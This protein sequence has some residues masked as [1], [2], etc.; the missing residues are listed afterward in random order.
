MTST[1]GKEPAAMPWPTSVDLHIVTPRKNLSQPTFPQPQT[2]VG[3]SQTSNTLPLAEA[4]TRVDNHSCNT[5]TSSSENPDLSPDED[6][7]DDRERFTIAYN[8]LAQRHGIRILVPGDFPS[9]T[10]HAD[11]SLGS[12]RGSWISKVLRQPSEQSRKAAA[13]SDKPTLRHHRSHSFIHNLQNNKRDGLK[14]LDLRALVRLCGRS[15][16][17]LPPEYAPFSLTLP[18]CFRALAQA[19]VQHADTRGIF[20]VSGSARA[21]DALYDYYC[22]NN[23]T[24]MENVS[25][26]T[27]CP[28]LPTHIKCNTHDVAGTFKRLLAGLPG[29]ILGSLSLFDAL[30]TIHSQLQGDPESYRTKE[31]RLRARLIAL[32]IGTVKSQYQRELICAVF[33][34]LCLVG[35]IAENAPRE[36]EN[37]HPLPTTDLMGYHALGI[38]FGPLLVGDLIDSYI[39]EVANPSAGLVLLP[40][41]A[42]RSKKEGHHQKHRHSYE[43]YHEHSHEHS[44][45]HEHKHE[46]KHRYEHQ[47]HERKHE[48]KHQHVHQH[49]HK[50][51]LDGPSTKMPFSVNKINVANSITEMLIVH[52]REVVRQIRDTGSVKTRRHGPNMP[53][54]HPESVPIELSLSASI[55]SFSLKE[56]VYRDQACQGSPCSARSSGVKSSNY[57]SKRD[58]STQVTPVV[59]SPTIE[60]CPTPPVKPL[61]LSD[62]EP[63]PLRLTH[64]ENT[65]E[66]DDARTEISARQEREDKHTMLQDNA[67]DQWRN[68]LASSKES[69]ESLA[70]SAKERRLK[71]TS[72]YV[73]SRPSRDV[74]VSGNSNPSTS[75]R[76]SQLTQRGSEK[77]VKSAALSSEKSNV[78]EKTPRLKSSSSSISP[79]R[80]MDAAPVDISPRG[81]RRSPSKPLPGAVKAMTALFDNALKEFPGSSPDVMNSKTA[82]SPSESSS[83]IGQEAVEESPIRFNPSRPTATSM[84]SATTVDKH[85]YQGESSKSPDAVQTSHSRHQLRDSPIKCSSHILPPLKRFTAMKREPQLSPEKEAYDTNRNRPPK[86]GTMLPYPEEPPIGHFLRPSSVTS[87]QGQYA[88]TDDVS[89]DQPIHRNASGNSMLHAQIRSLQRQLE[90]RHEEILQVRRQLEAQEHMDIGTLYEQLRVAKRECRMWRKRAEA[91]EKRLAI[92]QRFGDKFQALNDGVDEKGRG[93]DGDEGVLSALLVADEGGYEYEDFFGED[94]DEGECDGGNSNSNSDGDGSGDYHMPCRGRS[95][96]LV[97]CWADGPGLVGLRGNDGSVVWD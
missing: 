77:K 85:S 94:E 8:R 52:W 13:K 64:P 56:P 72:G 46:H 25:S 96:S 12:R 50:H 39:M 66:H 7:K 45:I 83:F 60:E 55:E 71:R 36:N 76:K 40:V 48:H 38:V 3:P 21:I 44:H 47:K 9:A 19:L 31:C 79:I 15:P 49:K 29:G 27:R 88:S 65:S 11:R 5:W 59:L 43:D 10:E 89:C 23:N 2:I 54:G 30:V 87:G 14:N 69:T 61:K 84:N 63:P 41:S 18:T 81:R 6:G 92:F 78:L 58:N 80:A 53:H 1:K 34:L 4:N 16:F 26:T 97:K 62:V 95:R 32:A 86:L 35:R 37:G 22:T 20:R 67:A 51:T 28:S 93:D 75:G 91:A 33:G 57:P 73:S 42:P 82:N 24:D 17:F 70:R 90:L 74:L 68:L